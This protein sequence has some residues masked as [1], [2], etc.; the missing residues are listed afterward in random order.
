MPPRFGWYEAD[1]MFPTTPKSGVPTAAGYSK[2]WFFLGHLKPGLSAKQAEADL[3]IIAG[4][5]AKFFPQDY[6][7]HF[8]VEVRSLTDNVS[9]RFQ[10]TLFTA[11]AGVALL[12]LIACG[13][14]ANLMLA[15]ATSREKEF[16]LRAVLAPAAHAW[17]ASFCS[18]VC[19]SP[20]G[21]RPSAH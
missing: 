21:L 6:P 9:G 17:S 15:R 13:N 10:T 16:A 19:S 12:L 20:W 3:A 8:T 1:V 18:K 11:W 4:R 2:S 14:V 7:T 5:E